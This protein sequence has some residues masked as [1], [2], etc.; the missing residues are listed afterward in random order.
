VVDGRLGHS[1]D[2]AFLERDLAEIGPDMD[3]AATPLGEHYAPRR[4]RREEDALH[5]RIK[6]F[7]VLLFCDVQRVAVPVQ[8]ALLTRMSMRPKALT[9]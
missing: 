1:V 7:V 9:V 3:D 4:L 6:G 8:L 2:S 5:R